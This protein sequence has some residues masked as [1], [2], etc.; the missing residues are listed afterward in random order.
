MLKNV[1]LGVFGVVAVFWCIGDAAAEA[2]LSEASS[3]CIDC[4]TTFQPGVVEGWKKSRHANVT[5]EQALSVKG[6]AN[7]ISNKDVPED[8]R[9]HAVGCAECHTLRPDAHADT[10]E[11]NGYDIHVVVSPDDCKTCHKTEV[12]QFSRNLMSYAVKNLA[13]NSVYQALEQSILGAAGIKGDHIKFGPIDEDTQAEACYYC[14]GTTL[15]VTGIE[16]RDTDAAGEL[17]F[18][19]ISG[20]PN[21]GVGR[22][23]LDGSRGSCTACHTRH[24]FSIEM[25]RKPYTCKECHIGPDVPVFKVY[26]A[27]KHG[28]IFSTKGDGWDFA[29]VPWTVGQDFTAPTCA[30]CH[31]SLLVNTE[32]ETVIE[33]SH[34]MNNRLPWRLFG[35]I[36]AHPYPK[37]ADTTIIRNKDGLPLPTDFNG[38]LAEGYLIDAN[39]Q[40]RRTRSLQGIC[41]NC[42]DTSWVSG[43][44][45]RFENTIRT[46]NEA[47]RTATMLMTEAWN[48]GYAKGLSAKENP[49]DEFIE[50]LWSD[51]WL[52]YAN[53]VR[54]SSAMGGGGDYGVFADGRYH[55]S[56]NLTEMR[57]WLNLRKA[58][59]GHQRAK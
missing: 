1:I 38:G 25:A 10:F 28:N 43:F 59:A 46:T 17:E 50:K 45:R 32:G 56:R 16:T 11:H 51:N 3:E 14:H 36:Y 22:I 12:E 47:T 5:P 57:D 20:W 13:E 34:Q 7:K 48:Q 9:S 55:L 23:N 40:A 54:F 21:Q 39:E 52:F 49:F 8:L 29:P 30:G 35:L 42:H 58:A 31:I 26:S 6:L 18:P 33:R 41:M 19:V 37:Q 2:P 4:H 27:S 15:K 44:W 53:T 24:E